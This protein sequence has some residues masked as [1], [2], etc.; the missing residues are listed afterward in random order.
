ME[1]DGRY[2][3]IKMQKEHIIQKLKERVWRITKQR[4]M[5]IQR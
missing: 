1:Q 4:L 2:Q 5:M 3:R